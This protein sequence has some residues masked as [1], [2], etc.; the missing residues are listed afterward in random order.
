M[1]PIEL[2]DMILIS[3]NDI[4]IAHKLSRDYASKKIY[5]Y[6]QYCIL[7]MIRTKDTDLV[8]LGMELDKPC[9]M[10]LWNGLKLA[11]EINSLAMVKYLYSYELNTHKHNIDLVQ[12]AI[13]YKCIGIIEY[14][15]NMEYKLC[16]GD[17]YVIHIAKSDDITKTSIYWNLF[18]EIALNYAI[19]YGDILTTRFMYNTIIDH[20]DNNIN[21]LKNTKDTSGLIHTLKM[22]KYSVISDI[23]T[24]CK[25][26][27]LHK[28]A[29]YFYRLKMNQY[30]TEYYNITPICQKNCD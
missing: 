21:E 19:I 7:D 20:I 26:N 27:N 15:Y 13:D 25:M 1:I 6:N 18:M 10:M 17:M 12:I 30:Y 11:V 24:K 14:L 29:D 9:E 3:L 23:I 22:N 16:S 8:G 2:F 28:M 4:S 5:R